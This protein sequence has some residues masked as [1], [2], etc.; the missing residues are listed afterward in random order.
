MTS[1][2]VERYFRD[3]LCDAESY[4][5]ESARPSAVVEETARREGVPGGRLATALGDPLDRVAGALLEDVVATVVGSATGTQAGVVV[6]CADLGVREGTEAY[7]ARRDAFVEELAPLLADLNPAARRAFESALRDGFPVLVDAAAY[8]ASLEGDTFAERVRA[9]PRERAR[10]ELDGAVSYVD[11][12]RRG[13][14]DPRAVYVERNPSLPGV[15]PIRIHFQ[16]EAVRLLD[17][18]GSH[19]RDRTRRTV[20]RAYANR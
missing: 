14:D 8:F 6:E 2:P 19:L 3:L 11:V 13:L 12:L 17:D 16:R 9:A 15:G 10:A 18:V 20:E 4:A 1:D 7:A 5:V